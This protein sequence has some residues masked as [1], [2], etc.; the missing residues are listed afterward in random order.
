MR[1][2]RPEP[3]GSRLHKLHQREAHVGTLASEGP[4]FDHPELGSARRGQQR[5]YVDT[6]HRM[7]VPTSSTHSR[8]SCPHA[9]DTDNP[10]DD[11]ATRSRQ[12][13]PAAGLMSP[14]GS[15][16]P[17][18]SS[19]WPPGLH[20]TQ[21]R[22][23]RVDPSQGAARRQAAPTG[24]S[25]RVQLCRWHHATALKAG[26]ELALSDFSPSPAATGWEHGPPVTVTG[27]LLFR[28]RSSAR[29]TR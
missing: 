15:P 29:V 4:G 22:P 27:A 9:A 2:T 28:P 24:M 18:T 25:R 10:T 20:R 19:S 12:A 7:Q 6:R 8:A 17:T 1:T 26:C 5:P 3:G 23:S 11:R 14:V 21:A 13:R 16:R